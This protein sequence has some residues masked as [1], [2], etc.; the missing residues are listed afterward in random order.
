MV[1]PFSSDLNYEDKCA[2]WSLVKGVVYILVLFNSLAI[3][4]S[5]LSS[6]SLPFLSPSSLLPLPSSLFPPPLLLLPFLPLSHLLPSSLFPSFPLV[7]SPA[8]M[9]PSTPVSWRHFSTSLWNWILPLANTGMFTFCLQNSVTEP[10]GTLITTWE[11]ICLQLAL[12][13]ST[14]TWLLWCAPSWPHL[15]LPP[16]A[17]L[18]DHALSEAMWVKTDVLNPTSSLFHQHSYLPDIQ[19]PLASWHS[20]LFSPHPQTLWSYKWLALIAH[21]EGGWLREA[22][23][24]THWNITLSLRPAVFLHYLPPPLLCSLSLLPPYR[25]LTFLLPSA[26]SPISL[27]RS[28]LSCKNAP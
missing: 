18:C 3:S 24:S 2:I 28:H 8:D 4:Y 20:A 17:P 21:D 22:N 1:T 15:C 11:H 9:T 10:R 14:L 27:R 19:P 5:S 7:N 12:S 23:T 6:T 26:G 25:F 13:K 16:S